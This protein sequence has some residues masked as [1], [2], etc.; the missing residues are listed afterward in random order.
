MNRILAVV[1]VL[2]GLGIAGFAAN[3]AANGAEPPVPSAGAAIEGEVLP[4]PTLESPAGAA[5]LYG[6]VR[7]QDADNT[8]T[9]VGTVHW[10]GAFGTRSV[11][12]R[13][14]AGEVPVELPPPERWRVLEGAEDSLEVHG[15]GQLPIVRDIDVGEHLSP[16]F[17][18][19]VR[20]IRPG[21]HVVVAKDASS[22]VPLYVGD[23]AAHVAARARREQGRWPI[24]LLLSVMAAV[25]FFVAHRARVGTMFGAPP[26]ED[27]I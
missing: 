13:T 22:R 11:R 19:T 21:D 15:L 2:L 9:N 12:V 27:A 18:I 1:F 16:P 17:R 14:A 6:E 3:V 5:F 25:S 7:L 24:V 8:Q 20:A 23:R 10:R 4:G 26:A